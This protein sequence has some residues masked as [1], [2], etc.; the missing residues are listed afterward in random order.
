MFEKVKAELPYEATFS[1][2]A[3]SSFMVYHTVTT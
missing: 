1:I 2:H 3:V